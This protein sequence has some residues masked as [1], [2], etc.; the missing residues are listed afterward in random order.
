MP[1]KRIF[2]EKSVDR[3]KEILDYLRNKQKA[4]EIDAKVNGINIWVLLGAMALVVWKIIATLDAPI[5]TQQSLI[6]RTLVLTAAVFFLALI[7]GKSQSVTDEIRYKS[8]NEQSSFESLLSALIML[9]PTGMFV[10]LVERSWSA[11][12]LLLLG[13]ALV[14]KDIFLITSELF[15]RR[16]TNGKFPK[17]ALGMT[18]LSDARASF[19]LVSFFTTITFD[20]AWQLI[21]EMKSVSVDSVKVLTLVAA[22]Y[23]LVLITMRRRLRT[24]AVLWTYEMETA[25]VTGAISA[26]EALRQIEYRA[27]RPR[28]TDVMKKFIEDTEKQFSDLSLLIATCR[29]NLSSVN[30]I[31]LEYQAER[32]SRTDETT[33][34]ARAHLDKLHHEIGEFAIYIKQLALANRANS[35]PNLLPLLADLE[36]KHKNYERRAGDEKRTLESLVQEAKTLFRTKPHA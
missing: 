19:V 24:A 23:L 13:I 1:I 2:Q 36:L 5:W 30:R 8:D 25:I 12:A 34:L 10:L 26:E 28:V 17:P 9:M 15:K 27:L 35:H 6:L 33:A 7:T 3:K 14:A 20:Q 18:K 32:T 22:A 11:I 21:R 4:Q 31:P 16:A 29:E